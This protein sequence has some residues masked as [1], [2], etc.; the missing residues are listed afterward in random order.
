ML[1]RKIFDWYG[2]KSATRKSL[3]IHLLLLASHKDHQTIFNG[4]PITI[5]RGQL[6]TG[7]KK[8]AEQIELSETWIEKVLKEFENYGQIRQQKTN[9]NRLIT[10]L[11]YEDYQSGDNGVYNGVY[12]KVTT[13]RQ[14]KDTIQQGNNENNETMVTKKTF[15][16]PSF[17][18]VRDY[19]LERNNGINPKEF[20]DKNDAIGWVVGKN[21]TPMKDWKA[22]IR[23]WEN[24]RNRPV[25][26]LTDVQKV[27]VARFQDW[28]KRQDLEDGKTNI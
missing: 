17:E 4:K 24:Y 16:R 27:N 25:D 11:K 8:L 22:T 23:T 9:T 10:I 5:S 14:Q 19:C 6:I 1:H 21:K 28:E 12:N 3:W 15:R 18:E 2:Y 7:R 20:I 26:M 13:K